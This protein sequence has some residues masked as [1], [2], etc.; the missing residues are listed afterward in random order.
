M[1]SKLWGRMQQ[2]GEVCVRAIFKSRE[3]FQLIGWAY[4]YCVFER[5]FLLSLYF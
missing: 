1:H 3:N 5:C 2:K 4:R